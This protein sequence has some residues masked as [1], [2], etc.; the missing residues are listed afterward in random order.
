MNAIFD[1]HLDAATRSSEAWF[2]AVA[3]NLNDPLGCWAMDSK[4][5]VSDRS[6]G[7]I[8]FSFCISDKL[9]FSINI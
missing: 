2:G 8:D 1:N 3:E 6:P 4:G 9:G 7:I 5:K